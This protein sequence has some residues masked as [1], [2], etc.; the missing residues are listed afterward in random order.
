[1]SSYVIICQQPEDSAMFQNL[2]WDS[3]RFHGIPWSSMRFYDVA[4]NRS[5]PT[6]ANR[7][8]ASYITTL[9]NTIYL[10]KPCLTYSVL[11]GLQDY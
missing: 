8:L 1:M 10:T 4:V 7:G 9:S 11:A 3:M 5:V 6:E 2:P